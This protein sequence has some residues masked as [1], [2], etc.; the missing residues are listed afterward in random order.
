MTQYIVQT[1]SD[2]L[3]QG[4]LGVVDGQ[5]LTKDSD[6]NVVVLGGAEGS[7]PVNS[8]TSQYAQDVM[9]ISSAKTLGE[10]FIFLNGTTFDSTGVGVYEFEEADGIVYGLYG[11]TDGLN[12]QVYYSG[13]ANNQVSL[14]Y[15]TVPYVPPFLSGSVWQ[16]G[17]I[18]GGDINGFVLLLR[19]TASPTSAYR[20]LWVKHNGTL[21][22]PTQHEY[23]E[24]TQVVQ[25][26][27][28]TWKLSGGGIPKI[29]RV[30]AFF[31]AVGMDWFQS[32]YFFAAW[33]ADE[34][35]TTA[36]LP[37]SI[38]PYSP[39]I[40]TLTTVGWPSTKGQ[41]TGTSVNLFGTNGLS[42][43][44]VFRVYNRTT[45]AIAQPV[46]LSAPLPIDALWS[47][48]IGATLEGEVDSGGV[49][50]LIVGAVIPMIM[51]DNN[52]P[53]PE[54]IYNVTFTPTAGSPG[55]F[56]TGNLTYNAIG[57]NGADAFHQQPFPFIVGVSP[58]FVKPDET[59]ASNPAA[60]LTCVDKLPVADYYTGHGTRWGQALTHHW[61]YS[62]TLALTATGSASD[63]RGVTNTGL[64]KG[65]AA[66][67]K[68]NK[69]A[70]IWPMYNVTQRFDFSPTGAS[71]SAS[72]VQPSGKMTQSFTGHMIAQDLVL[73]TAV[74]SSGAQGWVVSQLPA[75]S[76]ITDATYSRFGE[77]IPGFGG[78]VAEFNVTGMGAPNDANSQGYTFLNM[79]VNGQSNINNPTNFLFPSLSDR[80]D[81]ARFNPNGK[82][83]RQGSWQLI[84][85]FYTSPPAKGTYSANILTQLATLKANVLAA[86]QAAF[87]GTGNLGVY[88][89]QVVP[90]PNSAGTITRAIGMLHTGGTGSNPLEQ[91][92]FFMTPMAIGGDGTLQFTNPA[93]V[94]NLQQLSAATT[95]VIGT[96]GSND[97]EPGRV[98]VTYPSDGNTYIY[99]IPGIAL[100]V[101]G[102][103]T[104]G[105]WAMVVNPSGVTT[106]FGGALRSIGRSGCSCNPQQ[107]GLG[108]QP[109]FS[110]VNVPEVDLPISRY[111]TSTVTT[112]DGL[113]AGYTAAI[114]NPSNQTVTSPVN[115]DNN[116][117]EILVLSSIN[118]QFLL[119]VGSINGRLNHQEF[120][121][122]SSFLDMTNAAVGTYYLYIMDN[123]T[124]IVLHADTAQIPDDESHMFFG[125]FDRTSTGF[126]NESSISEVVRFGSAR[127]LQG[128]SGE[129]LPGSTIRVGPYVTP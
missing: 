18:C 51:P 45:G 102:D 103:N 108:I 38:T 6:D 73:S 56:T 75:N 88:T 105:V 40:I 13:G 63:I 29:V 17:A 107:G 95:T 122:P 26:F 116:L 42:D 127:L 50:R 60:P 61:Y 90:L 35:L 66:A 78:R 57:A 33:N 123:G 101:T 55:A 28:S 15:T 47:T 77:A 10:G 104:S 25:S 113:V 84:N 126:A 39:Q 24:I 8:F 62:G 91:H 59:V 118:N 53:N 98:F 120:S 124:D 20:Y 58:M 96:P 2:P 114:A 22:D 9:D 110:G 106:S 70:N 86:A 19:N 48:N 37:S 67:A 82:T 125:Q 12:Q 16:A 41:A 99:W 11:R 112:I 129:V 117:A 52:S 79:W 109:F 128:S 89:I 74:L 83:Y 44:T 111:S 119:Q 31:F 68:A 54:I 49:V 5:L 71:M 4:E 121:L 76:H 27:Q 64:Q 97:L 72:I 46:A 1:S 34:S 115:L 87:P 85:G 36:A 69:L 94:T 32:S 7:T 80:T 3:T 21:I 23:M 92:T 81:D 14:Q 65:S 43:A 100:S 30:G 93:S